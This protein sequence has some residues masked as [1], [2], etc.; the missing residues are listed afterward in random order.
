MDPTLLSLLINAIATP[1]LVLLTMWFRSSLSTKERTEK[2]EDGFITGMEER[3]AQL[4]REVREVRIE[5]KNR[6]AEY[7]DLF[8]VYTTLKA[9][10]EVLEADHEELKKQYNATA[11]EL[12]TLKDDIKQK[13]DEAAASIQKI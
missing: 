4:E 3:I 12:G 2:R 11:T 8:K 13:A 5:L 9:K 1:L 6:D 7:L 10:H